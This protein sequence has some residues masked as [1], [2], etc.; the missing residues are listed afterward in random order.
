[1]ITHNRVTIFHRHTRL[2]APDSD[3]ML[4]D[5][6]TDT[7]GYALLPIQND[8]LYAH[9]FAYELWIGPIPPDHRVTRTCGH[10][11]CVN[12]NHLMLTTRQQAPLAPGSRCPAARNAAKTHCRRGHEFTPANT[13]RK[14]GTNSR[15]CRACHGISNAAYRDR[16]AAR[17][18][19]ATPA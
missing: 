12:P 9:R 11:L 14:P 15:E 17:Q 18:Q 2:P 6:V 4:W 3:C 1:V 7:H 8:R 19:E 16:L 13:Y 5:W 10:H